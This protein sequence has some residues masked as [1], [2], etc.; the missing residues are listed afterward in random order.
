[1][2][3]LFII[4]LLLKCLHS[5]T[6][7]CF[8]IFFL[9][10]VYL[11]TFKAF[12]ISRPDFAIIADKNRLHGIG[13][14]ETLYYE[15][16]LRHDHV[17][18]CILLSGK[19]TVWCDGVPIHGIYPGQF[20]N[21]VEWASVLQLQDNLDDFGWEQ[22]VL[23]R[24]DEDSVYLRIY[25]DHLEWLKNHKNKLWKLLE[26]IVCTDVSQKLHQMN[27]GFEKMVRH[28]DDTKKTNLVRLSVRSVSLEALHVSSKGWNVSD[29]WLLADNRSLLLGS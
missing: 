15:G 21:S 6:T 12:S 3:V 4:I 24:P 8:L 7:S 1:M 2:Y 11:T 5:R 13:P 23:I 22:Q 28:R 27:D 17:D 9:Q 10:D 18:L 26:A 25:G 29:N 19:M 20:I 14:D 16:N